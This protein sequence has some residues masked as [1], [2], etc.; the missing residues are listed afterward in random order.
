ML[1]RLRGALGNAALWAASWFTISLGV[2]SV[3]NLAGVFGTYPDQWMLTLLMSTQAGLSGFA[4]GLLFSGYLRLAHRDRSIMDISVLRSTV[5]GAG[6]AALLPIGS[7]LLWMTRIDIYHPLMLLVSALPAMVLG[8][9][10]AGG[11]L[12]AARQNERHAIET[13]RRSALGL[14]PE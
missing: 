12:A 5:A 7:T 2:F 1:R 3:L 10:T 14:P 8:A 11:T 13:E 6:I 4:T 9:V